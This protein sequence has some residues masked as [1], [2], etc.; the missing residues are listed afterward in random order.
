MRAR[1]TRGMATSYL[2]LM[3]AGIAFLALVIMTVMRL[4]RSGGLFGG[5]SP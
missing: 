5:G 1:A 2:V 4:M 3:I